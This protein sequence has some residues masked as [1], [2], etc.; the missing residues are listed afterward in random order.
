MPG[1]SWL[2]WGVKQPGRTSTSSVS[3]ANTPCRVFRLLSC[4][5]QSGYY[6]YTKITIYTTKI[7]LSCLHVAFMMS[8]TCCVSN[9]FISEWTPN[10]QASSRPEVTANGFVCF[11]SAM[12]AWK[13]SALTFSS[14]SEHQ[15]QCSNAWKYD[16]FKSL[17]HLWSDRLTQGKPCDKNPSTN[18]VECW[19]LLPNI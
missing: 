18:P 3:K 12:Y 15:K 13:M 1:T 5:E 8:G 7:T 9:A 11:K 16:I 4:S 2:K 19:L 6:D 17:V 14:R 10:R